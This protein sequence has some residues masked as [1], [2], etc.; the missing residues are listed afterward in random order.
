MQDGVRAQAR[1]GPDAAV[2]ADDG[3]L[4]DRVREHFRVGADARVL[5][6]AIRADPDAGTEVHLADEHRVHVDV[7]VALDLDIAAD[8]DACR[9]D[10]RRAGEHEI[11][12]A[13]LAK[14]CFH[15]GELD[16]VVDAHDFIGMRGEHGLDAILGLHGQ[17]DDIGEVVLALG[18]VSPEAQKPRAQPAG[19][20]RH[21][22]GIHLAGGELRG[23]RVLVL[24]DGADLAA[25][26]AHDAPVPG[27]VAEIDREH[28]KRAAGRE[29]DEL[30]EAG[31][32]D[33][34]HIPVQHQHRVLVGNQ[35]HGLHHGMSGAELI[36][37]QHPID[38]LVL[39]R[40]LDLGAAVT[41][42]DADIGRSQ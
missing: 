29:V 4:D 42:H 38:V 18:V 37:L 21:E 34:G 23:A 22:P 10:E 6:D 8:I 25:G 2:L 33:Q 41:V 11:T 3:V 26:I 40:I 15:L 24:D 5:D 30:P 27:S 31:G 17:C 16:L 1:E 19:R 20:R 14:A 7:H 13:S 35:G 9:I 39:E 12:R 32:T 28:G 36:G